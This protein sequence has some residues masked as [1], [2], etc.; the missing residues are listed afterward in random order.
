[1]G[2]PNMR[3]RLAVVP[4][5]IAFFFIATPR[6]P[7]AETAAE[8]AALREAYSQPIPWLAARDKERFQRGRS[9][10]RQNRVAAPAVGGIAGLGPLYNRPSCLSCHP[11]NGR[12]SSPRLVNERLL[13][14][15]V[16]LSLPGAD[17]HGGPRP[18]PV[19]GGQLNEEGVAGV[20]GEGRAA[21]HWVNL[22]EESLAGGERIALR[23]PLIG[24]D[25]LAYGKPGKFLYSLN[26]A[27]DN[28]TT[29]RLDASG[30]PKFTGKFLGVGS[31]AVMEF[32][33]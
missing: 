16:R 13:S 33:P 8:L 17:E 18:H 5:L 6:C 2:T 27:G 10:F 24:F 22:P 29:F 12:G 9:L 23:R 25:D 30:V 11:N 31:P 14:M 1:M 19:Y 15:V 26:Q 3:H 7:A 21:I 32:L 28:L 20:P 4:A